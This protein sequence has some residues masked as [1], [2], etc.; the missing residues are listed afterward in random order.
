MRETALRSCAFDSWIIENL[1]I[2]ARAGSVEIVGMKKS[3]GVLLVCSLL[4]RALIH[5]A[6]WKFEAFHFV[7]DE[8]TNSRSLARPPAPVIPLSRQALE[9]LAAATGAFIRET[10]DGD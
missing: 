1:E 2:T 7:A 8:I 3:R 5:A 10:H 9:K 6:S 4:S